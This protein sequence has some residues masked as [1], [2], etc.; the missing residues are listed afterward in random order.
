MKNI[1]MKLLIQIVAVFLFAGIAFS[2]CGYDDFLENEYDYTAVY[3]AHDTISRSFIM[4]EGMRIGVG[5]T[6][7]GVL[8]NTKDV[9][10]T[11]SMATDSLDADPNLAVLPSEYYDLVDADGNTITDL[12]ITIPAGS[13]QGFVYVQA[14]SAAL[15][16]D[17]LSL[18]YNYALPF[19]LE[20]VVNADSILEDYQSTVIT[21]TYINQLYGYFVQYG[22][23]TKSDGVTDTVVEYPGG[24]DDVVFLEMK[25]PT[26]MKTTSY[27][28]INDAEMNITLADD[29]TITIT[30]AD[31]SSPIIDNGGSYYDSTTRTIMLNYSFD[32]N[33]YTYTATD[34][35]LF[36]NR[37][38]DGVNQYNEDLIQY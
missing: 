20:S 38:V 6:L 21:F 24:I 12:V 14:D 18:G 29:N 8:S 5:V 2:S 9:E 37:V 31:E 35:L 19:K 30:S 34:E 33:G 15:L 36:R 17:S 16:A 13:V 10:V 4:G 23:Y 26:T 1:K 25:S 28:D 11:F 27:S 3:L 32:F 22:S 7:G